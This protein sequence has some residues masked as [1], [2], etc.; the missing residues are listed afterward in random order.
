MT[1][2]A[3]ATMSCDHRAPRPGWTPLDPFG[4]WPARASAVRGLGGSDPTPNP[5]YAFHTSYLFARTG[6]IAFRGRFEGLRADGGIL[7]MR[8]RCM[9]GAGARVVTVRRVAVPL[10]AVAAQGGHW[11]IGVRAR[12]GRA[13]ALA[14]R[15]EDAQGAAA[16]G[17]AMELAGRDDGAWHAERLREGV[18]AVLD[19]SP[20]RGLARLGRRGRLWRAG[21]LATEPATIARPVSQMCTAAQMDEPD[22]LRLL[23]K[24]Q[25]RP[26]R[27]RKLWEFIYILAVLERH[28]TIRPGARGLGFGCGGEFMPS[29]LAAEGCRVLATD[30][31]PDRRQAA[32]WIDTGQHASSLR[33]LHWP[34]LC[35]AD[36]FAAN[37]GFRAVDMRAIPDD[38]RG[39]DF[40]W[41]A[42]A[43]EHLGSIAAGLRF[44]E[45]SLRTL[46]PGGIAVHTTELNLCS[47]RRTID[48][49][50]TVL[51]RRRDM[52]RLAA[53]LHA[54]GHRVL[55]LNFDPGD[56]PPDLHVDVPPFDPEEHLKIAL[57]RFVT[58]SFGFAVVRRG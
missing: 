37:V 43:F 29:L 58:T 3:S 22:F 56:R 50:A 11:S 9:R 5:A 53:R 8:V 54:A 40:C 17:L 20:P 42:C 39:F 47:N 34:A 31:P 6:P 4:L 7:V 24:V 51:F 49:E 32:G 55:P 45:R 1:L 28:G 27:H 2:S 15:I 18:T 41:S 46:A 30:M 35:P 21:L 12:A 19:P 48:R 38:L 13:Y 26:H 14:G 44:V 33:Q 16:D 10:A 36:A 57:R 23:R 52:E 25:H